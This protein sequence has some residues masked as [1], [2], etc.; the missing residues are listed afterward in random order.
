HEY[1]NFKSVS[2][3]FP[4]SF[5][6]VV[7]ILFCRETQLRSGLD[8]IQPR[9][10]GGKIGIIRFAGPPAVT[11]RPSGNRCLPTLRPDPPPLP[12]VP[13]IPPRRLRALSMH[14]DRPPVERRAAEIIQSWLDGAPPDAAGA[15]A[16]HPE[17]TTDKAIVLDLAFA[18]FL[19]R[20]LKG[21]QLDME[22][23]CARFPE[24]HASLG[25]MLA[26][27]SV[28]ERT[29]GGPDGALPEGLAERTVTVQIHPIQ[30]THLDTSRLPSSSTN[31]PATPLMGGSGSSINK[32]GGPAWP[33]PGGKVG[34]FNLLRQ[35]GKGAFGRVFLALEEP[36][37]RHVVVKIS[38]QK[39]DEAKVLGR[40]GHRN[41]VA[42][43]SAPH[44]LLSG[45]Y[46]IVMPYHGSSTFE[47][48]L[49]LAYPLRKCGS[50]RPKSARVIIEAAH[51]NL[52]P[53][54]PVPSDLRADPF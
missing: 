14:T 16:R 52:Q 33:E 6:S 19:V 51:R 25:R 49:E 4:T 43:L 28:G 23:Y 7:S 45:L 30:V 17:F 2:W 9:R 40:L 37:T 41:V 47:D 5:H 26:Q 3:H 44:D 46:L 18:E 1:P 27:Q 12:P 31:S 54:D 50:D 36:T 34:D 38:R 24:Y 20:E 11:Y 21:E 42:V 8:G 53:A 48:L 32:R 39:C 10:E 35:L 22:E 15:L 13:A 29:A